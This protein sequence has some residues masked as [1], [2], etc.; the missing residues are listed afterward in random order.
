MYYSGVQGIPRSPF[1]LAAVAIIY[2][3]SGSLPELAADAGDS[4]LKQRRGALRPKYSN[5]LPRMLDKTP[6]TDETQKPVRDQR[7]A[8]LQGVDAVLAQIQARREERQHLEQQKTELDQ[9]LQSLEKFKLDE[10]KPY[11]FLLRDSLRDQLEIEKDR[12]KA[13]AA[14]GKAASKLL[15]AA[16]QELD[17]SKQA[18]PHPA[19]SDDADSRPP[20]RL[21]HHMKTW[22]RG[23]GHKSSCAQIEVEIN[24]R[25]IA[26]CEAKQA[27]I[28]QKL[29]V[30]GDD[31]AFSAQDPRH[32][33]RRLATSEA[34]LKGQRRQVERELQR[35]EEEGRTKPGVG[36]RTA[37]ARSKGRGC[38]PFPRRTTD[39]CQSQIVLLDQRI[40]WLGRLRRVW[41][42]RYDVATDRWMQHAWANGWM[43]SP[44]FARNLAMRF[45]HLRIVAIR[46][47]P[48]KRGWLGHRAAQKRRSG[49]R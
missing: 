46:R 30:I 14:D 29:K 40:D 28:T 44:I 41:R 2:V 11:S 21:L 36:R 16:H 24:A 10:P 8:Q 26:V 27:E 49:K 20:H 34:R 18:E 19:K 42:Q 1:L 13:L 47:E 17:Q 38:Q 32:T 15:A 12:G 5:F 7:L 39:A 25:R 37:I 9:S 45:A 23:R 43:I 48:N 35:I 3:A 22:P 6:A 4:S 31:V 33:T